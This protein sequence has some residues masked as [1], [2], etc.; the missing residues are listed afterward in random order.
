M[1]IS[2]A[3]TPRTMKSQSCGIP[4]SDAVLPQ[5]SYQATGANCGHSDTGAAMSSNRLNER[6]VTGH[7]VM[8]KVG[9]PGSA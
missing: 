3:A 7:G 9:I 1:T 2:A 5:M 6:I 8:P 4:S